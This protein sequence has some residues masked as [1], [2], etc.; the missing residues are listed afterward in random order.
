MRAPLRK[1]EGR[2]RKVESDRGRSPSIQRSA[3]RLQP[4]VVGSG[5]AGLLVATACAVASVSVWLAPAYLLLVVVILAAPRGGRSPS[6]PGPAPRIRLRAFAGFLRHGLTPGP[7]RA[8][9]APPHRGEGARRADEGADPAATTA[10]PG[11]RPDEGP[12]P[13]DEFE[14]AESVRLRLDPA[15]MAVTKPRRSRVRPRRAAKPDA[16]PAAR[17]SSQR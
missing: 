15:A 6:K 16:E 13:A 4:F 2:M 5:L 11:E 10:H 12:D 9:S 3:F 17:C 7:R 8:P 14:V 1:A